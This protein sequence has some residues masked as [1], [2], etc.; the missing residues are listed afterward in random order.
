MNPIYTKL[1]AWLVN[2]GPRLLSVYRRATGEDDLFQVLNH[3]Q[4]ARSCLKAAEMEEGRLVED[5][6]PDEYRRE[7]R[8][9]LMLAEARLRRMSGDY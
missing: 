3:V 6:S 4:E 8:Q 7:A 5:W 9:Q 1:L 2:V